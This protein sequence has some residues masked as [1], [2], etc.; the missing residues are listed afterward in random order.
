M[1][2]DVNADSGPSGDAGKIDSLNDAINAAIKVSEEAPV[3]EVKAEEPA[4]SV[5]AEDQ[6]RV[7]EDAKQAAE[8]PAEAKKDGEAKPDAKTFEAPHHW[9]EADKQA[10]AGLPQ[11]AQ[12]IIR[13]LAR[14]LEAGHTRKSQE[15]GSKAKYAEVVSS[16]IDDATRQELAQAGA[17]DLQYFQFLHQ[18][19]KNARS[20]GPGYIR[21]AMQQ[22]R[23]TPEQ[24]G[25]AAPQPAGPPPEPT[26]DE[27]LA[28][29]NV[30]RLEAELAQLKGQWGEHQAAQQRAIQ[31]RQAY[32]RQGLVNLA[33]SFRGALDDAGQLRFP[34]FDQ[35]HRQM[36][37]LMETDHQLAQMPDGPEKMQAAYDMAVWAR[38]DLRQSFVEA[39]AA[40]RFQ[41][42]EKAREAQRA[43]SVT[44]VR[45]AASVATSPAKSSDLDAIIRGA[46]AERGIR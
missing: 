39:E 30:K 38:P 34:H 32:E 1:A 15:L 19:Q 43:R 4:P 11:E 16:L 9:P 35:V 18:L 3:S 37:A 14:D 6:P 13:R 29:P 5:K 27:V 23:V 25:I 26:L 31:H 41:A 20:N 44:Q 36:G 40:K 10:F 33:N 45:P 8:D 24:L 42:A 17:N 28:D 7:G 22:L 2:V 46:M 21:W 12:A